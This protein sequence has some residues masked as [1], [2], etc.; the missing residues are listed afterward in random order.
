M[1][2]NPPANAP[3]KGPKSKAVVYIIVSPMLKNPLV[4]GTYIVNIIVATQ[5]KAAKMAAS[6]SS[7]T[8]NFLFARN[9]SA[10]LTNVNYL[11]VCN[12]RKDTEKKELIY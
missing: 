8:D 2:P 12:L 3:T 4:A 6:L 1:D 11:R 5:T 10:N 9:I 7:T